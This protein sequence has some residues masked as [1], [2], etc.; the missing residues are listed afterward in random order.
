MRLALKDVGGEKEE[1]V[2]RRKHKLPQSEN[3]QRNRPNSIQRIT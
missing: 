1:I 3:K 2:L